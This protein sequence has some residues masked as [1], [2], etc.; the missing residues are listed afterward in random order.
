MPSGMNCLANTQVL[1]RVLAVGRLDERA[2]VA[3][4][5]RLEEHQAGGRRGHEAEL[6]VVLQAR[7]VAG[8]RVFDHVEVA[9]Q[10][11]GQARAGG[12]HRHELHFLPVGLLAPILFVADQLD[13]SALHVRLQGVRAGADG[14]LA[15]VEV[16]HRRPG[17]GHAATLLR[18]ERQF[19]VLDDAV[20]DDGQRAGQFGGHQREGLTGLDDDGVRIRRLDVGDALGHVHVGLRHVGF[21]VQRAADREQHVLGRRPG[22][23]TT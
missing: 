11:A 7:Q 8:G 9:G 3:A 12:R 18:V 6:R 2:R 15:V 1:Q 19:A 21:V 16:G 20:P 5:V 17:A 4:H 23:S 13:A 14:V 10:Q 22:S